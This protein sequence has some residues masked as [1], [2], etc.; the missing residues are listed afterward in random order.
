MGFDSRARVVEELVRGSVGTP[1]EDEEKQRV[2]RMADEAARA[3]AAMRGVRNGVAV[4]GSARDGPVHRWG[5][6][7]RRVSHALTEAG[8]TAITGGGPG[9][10]AAVNDGAMG[11]G[12]R[13]V[14]LTIQLP[15][16]EPAND[17][18]TLEVPF[19]YFF[20]RKLVFVKYSC[21][22]VL[23]PGGFGTLDELFEALNLRRTHRLDPFPVI[24]LG[25]EYW[26]GLVEW[27]RSS[28]V[29]AGALSS[30]D[31]DSLI[32]TDDVQCVVDAVIE[33]HATL[34]R[35][36]GIAP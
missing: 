20:L 12:G 17:F 36:L 19:H 1:I 14:G 16:D 34:C 8:F 10:M 28:A 24:L 33:C 3:F 11:A 30:E 22:F 15:V 2:V 29:D 35:R 25:A 13:S 26:A 6:L 9:L 18:L 32:V 21:A 5:H 7:A 27:L 31:V 4:F 23:L